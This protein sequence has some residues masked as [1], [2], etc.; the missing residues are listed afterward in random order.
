[1]FKRLLGYFHKHKW[2]SISVNRWN[3]SVEEHCDCGEY[4]YHLWK[5]AN[6]GTINWQSGKHPH[7][8]TNNIVED[9]YNNINTDFK[10]VFK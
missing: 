10:N 7:I 4:R 3:I 1:M 8:V 2:N 6:D 5:H 9:M